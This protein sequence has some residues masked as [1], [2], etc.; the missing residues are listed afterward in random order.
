M[1]KWKLR[2]LDE[3]ITGKSIDYSKHVRLVAIY[4]RVIFLS[5][6]SD[7][8]DRVN[9]CSIARHWHRDFLCLTCPQFVPDKTREITAAA[10]GTR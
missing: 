9:L 2:N 4:I 10:A 8:L 6:F 3:M 1:M 7:S 5:D